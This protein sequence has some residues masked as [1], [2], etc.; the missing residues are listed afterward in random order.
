[1]E[2]KPTRRKIDRVPLEFSPRRSQP[3]GRCCIHKERAVTKYKSLPLL[4]WDMSDETD[5]LTPLSEYARKALERRGKIKENIL[6]VIDEACSSC[7]QVN[8]EV[9]N[10][11]RG[12]VAR[13]CYMNCPKGAIHFDKRPDRPAL[14]MTPVLVA[15]SAIK[16]VRITPLFI[17]P[18][19]AKKHVR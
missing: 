2:G 1:M 5:E 13:S 19:H 7:V 3:V 18:F 11:C 12:C 4:G 16:V 10:L 17:F 14:T 8:Y 6:C 9:S 15:V